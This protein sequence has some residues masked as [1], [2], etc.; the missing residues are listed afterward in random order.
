MKKLFILVLA[1]VGLTLALSS[2]TKTSYTSVYN[3]GL[4]KF[5]TGV[6]V[7]LQKLNSISKLTMLHSMTTIS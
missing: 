2:C 7:T 6:L 4:S 1:I 3:C 5:N